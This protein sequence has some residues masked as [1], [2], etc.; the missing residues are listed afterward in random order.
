MMEDQNVMCTDNEDVDH[1]EKLKNSCSFCVHKDTILA[2]TRP[3]LTRDRKLK[4]DKDYYD[5]GKPSRRRLMFKSISNSGPVVSN[6]HVTTEQ[7]DDTQMDS[8]EEMP[9]VEHSLCVRMWT[10]HPSSQKAC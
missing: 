9:C 3:M 1:R 2:V 7:I 5:K 4:G 10:G 6:E 8:K